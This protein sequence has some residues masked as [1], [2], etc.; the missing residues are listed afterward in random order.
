ML[1]VTL[2]NVSHTNELAASHN[3][4][5]SNNVVILCLPCRELGITDADA[6]NV[7]AKQI[8]SWEAADYQKINRTV[9][10]DELYMDACY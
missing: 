8:N 10:S 4:K 3:K 5:L 9:L 6:Y 7:T 1:K 2:C